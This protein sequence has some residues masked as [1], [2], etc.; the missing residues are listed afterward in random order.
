MIN[1]MGLPAIE[2]SEPRILSRPDHDVSRDNLSD[3]ALKVLYRLHRSWYTA[4]LLG[5]SVSDLL[6]GRRP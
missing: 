1:A 5:G 4:Y 6:L 2:S 3:E